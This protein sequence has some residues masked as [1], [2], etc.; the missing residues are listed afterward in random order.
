MEEMLSGEICKWV[1]EAGGRKEQEL[2]KEKRKMQF[3]PLTGAA[4][5]LGTSTLVIRGTPGGLGGAPAA[6]ATH[7]CSLI[8]KGTKISILDTLGMCVKGQQSFSLK[9][10]IRNI[11]C[12]RILWSLS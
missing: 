6:S 7:P 5:D 8:L 2:L 10:Q 9:G 11:L 4:E 3:D 1:R 12:L